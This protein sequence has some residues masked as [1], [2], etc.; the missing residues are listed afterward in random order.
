MAVLL[1]S[2]TTAVNALR[3]VRIR[4][5]KTRPMN[6]N[7]NKEGVYVTVFSGMKN[8]EVDENQFFKYTRMTMKLFEYL[9]QV[10]SFLQKDGKT[11][12]SSE[13]RLLITIQ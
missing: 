13:H 11:K 7:R 5:F 1:L 10:R 12:L 2:L 6:R 8:K 4:R 3:K 9:L